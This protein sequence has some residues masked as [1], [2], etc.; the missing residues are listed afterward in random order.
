MKVK[1]VLQHSRGKIYIGKRDIFAEGPIKEMG[2]SEGV[3]DTS[4]YECRDWSGWRKDAEVSSFKV[5]HNPM[6]DKTVETILPVHDGG[7]CIC[8]RDCPQGGPKYQMRRKHNGNNTD[9]ER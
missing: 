7:I 3:T 4:S 2:Y 1:D 8:Y 6:F 5:H 9:T